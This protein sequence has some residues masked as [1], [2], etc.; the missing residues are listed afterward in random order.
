MK[1]LFAPTQKNNYRA[2]LMKTPILLAFILI[3]SLFNFVVK[4][5][6]KAQGIANAV[7]IE[8]LLNGHNLE[9]AN[10]GAS[11]LRIDSKLVAS[12][13]EKAIKMLESNCW[14]HYCPDGQSPWTFFDNA[15]Y[16]YV[17]A[18]EN[19]A[20][21]Y[22]DI[23]DLMSAWMNSQTHRENIL[24]KNYE[25]VGFG[26][27][28]GTYQGSQNNLLVVA[29]F[30]SE[31]DDLINNDNAEIN[32]V[33][34]LNNTIANSEDLKVEGT[35]NG[36]DEVKIM[37][38]GELSGEA[39]IDRG[40]FTYNLK[41][42]KAGDNYIYA[43]A[44]MTF[45]MTKDSGTIKVI[46]NKEDAV[47]QGAS[48]TTPIV[49]TFGDV[50]TSPEIKNMINLGFIVALALLFLID[51]LVLSRSKILQGDRSFSHYHFGLFFILAI[52]VLAGG[53]G[54]NLKDAIR[55]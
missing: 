26:I 27:V 24:N 4:V 46:Y 28:T 32:I 15:G 7:T 53:F 50:S 54:G 8:N 40:L 38:N 37:L 19:L 10:V 14:S 13:Q 36:S 2:Y 43:Q 45:G 12:A 55:I 20:E 6:T 35:V 17:L 49:G 16:D 18:G 44:P 41:L 39:S 25:E 9:R 42:A 30:G 47:V 51:F 21:G 23:Q 34:P 1:N 11:G 33:S 29:H 5:D 31:L 52:I 22:Y 3:I 48:A